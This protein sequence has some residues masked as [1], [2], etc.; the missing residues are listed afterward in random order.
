MIKSAAFLGACALI[1]TSGIASAQSNAP[2]KAPSLA[3]AI[4]AAQ[5]AIDTCS[6]DGFKI[7]AAVLDSNG[8]MKVFLAADGASKGAVESSVKKAMTALKLNEA[9][10]E[11]IAKMKTDAALKAKVDGDSTLFVRPGGLLI[12]AGSEHLGAFG[13][14]GVPGSGGGGAK[15]E[16]CAKAGLDK[17]KARLK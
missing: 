17:V 8:G 4:E 15:D 2:G 6:K 13:V 16:A 1:A 10:S 12:M 11:T 5:T 7:S 9:T 14:G 3:L